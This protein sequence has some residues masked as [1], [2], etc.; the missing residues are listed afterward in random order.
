MDPSNPEILRIL[1]E[2][3]VKKENEVDILHSRLLELRQEK[4]A[5][6]QRLKESIKEGFKA[7][8]LFRAAIR[9]DVADLSSILPPF[10]DLSS[11]LSTFRV[12]GQEAAGGMK[13][14]KSGD[15]L[16]VS[17]EGS[18]GRQPYKVVQ[19]IFFN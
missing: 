13:R 17:A 10:G 19:Y 8:N 7:L 12:P 16:D 3:V 15:V 5:V 2:N 4:D 6:E 18:V 1:Q 9:R 14:V 11:S